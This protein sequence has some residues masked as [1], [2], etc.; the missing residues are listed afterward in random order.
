M[1][2]LK[3]VIGIFVILASSPL[4]SQNRLGGLDFGI[5]NV[6]SIRYCKYYNLVQDCSE[7]LVDPIFLGYGASCFDSCVYF[8]NNGVS[9]RGHVDS[10]NHCLNKFERPCA[11]KNYRSNCS[12][13]ADTLPISFYA[14]A[15]PYYYRGFQKISMTQTLCSPVMLHPSGRPSCCTQWFLRQSDLGAFY[16]SNFDSVI[17]NP[18]MYI[19]FGRDCKKS[20]VNNSPVYTNDPFAYSCA[21]SNFVFDASG[22][23]VDGHRLT[24]LLTNLYERVTVLNCSLDTT[25][26]IGYK[27]GLS[28]KQPFYTN[29][30]FAIDSLTGIITANFTDTMLY[31]GVD[32]GLQFGVAAV[33]VREYDASNNFV[34]SSMRLIGIQVV[35]CDTNVM[36]ENVVVSNIASVISYDTFSNTTTFCPGDLIEFDISIVDSNLYDSLTYSHTLASNIP[37]AQLVCDTSIVNNNP[38]KC[39]FIWQTTVNDTLPKAFNIKVNDSGGCPQVYTRNYPFRFKVDKPKPLADVQFCKGSKS[40]ILRVSGGNSYNWQPNNLFTNPFDSIAQFKPEFTFNNQIVYISVDSECGTLLDTINVNFVQAIPLNIL[41]NGVATNDTVIY[42]GNSIN[43]TAQLGVGSNLNIQWLPNTNLSCDT[44]VNTIANPS[45]TQTYIVTATDNDGCTNSDTINVTVLN[46]NFIE[47]PNTI[48]P[49]NDGIN[50]ELIIIT[51]GIELI[52]TGRIFNRWGE[53]IYETNNVNIGSTTLQYN[54]WNGKQT[55]NGQTLSVGTLVYY[56]EAIDVDGALITKAGDLSL[57]K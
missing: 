5:K 9:F 22:V 12:C 24:Y 32:T 52:N 23:D 34:A 49:N 13:N 29:G 8:S 26:P 54:L 39:K 48:T 33:K 44:C 46:N 16:T 55:I 11:P 53:L 43:L 14:N 18:N 27:A 51:A 38:L 4:F 17:V 42:K 45:A 20:Y 28:Y 1:D 6:D 25:E 3:Y 36:P 7:N 30:G 31:N 35:K 10:L 19:H 56:I 41:A 40:A 2:S 50:D 37:G 47:V 57:L 21:S 15:P